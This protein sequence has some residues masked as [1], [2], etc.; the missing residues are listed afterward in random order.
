MF[1]G[2]I[3]VEDWLKMGYIKSFISCSML[4][5]KLTCHIKLTF[6]CSNRA[7]APNLVLTPCM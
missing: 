2:G 6:G 1:S 7:M 4:V 5:R 3:E